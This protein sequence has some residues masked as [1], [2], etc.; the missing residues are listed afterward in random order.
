MKK[1]RRNRKVYERSTEPPG[2]KRR[3]IPDAPVDEVWARVQVLLA[4]EAEPT[5]PKPE[6]AKTANAETE[7]SKRSEHSS[8]RGRL[9]RKIW[10]LDIVAVAAWSFVFTKLFV[11][12]VDRYLL[13]AVAPELLW[14]LDYRVVLALLLL[15]MVLLLFKA[16]HVAGAI[17]YISAYPIVVLFW[18]VPL[19]VVKRWRVARRASSFAVALLNSALAWT[20][21][22]KWIMLAISIYTVSAL[23]IALLDSPVAIYTA[24]A[25]ML[26]TLGWSLAVSVIDMFRSSRLIDLQRR[27]ITWILDKDVLDRLLVPKHPD[28]VAIRDWTLADAKA[29][30]DS[31]GYAVLAHRLLELW[32]YAIDEYRRGPALV[33]QNVAA[34]VFMLIQ[35]VVVFSFIN[36]GIYVASS[37][38]YD[39][40]VQPGWWTWLYYSASALTFGEIDAIAP[41]GV[42][43]TIAK[44]MNGWIGGIGVLT[45]VVTF[46]ISIRRKRTEYA[47]DRSVKMLA[48][49][50]KSIEEM[51]RL[52]YKMGI[53]ELAGYL[54]QVAWGLNLLS[55]WLFEKIPME[56]RLDR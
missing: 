31:A 36:G 29:Y 38:Q 55:E 3:P 47:V 43:A 19:F 10:V 33:L 32:A 27:S 1:E 8:P 20:A 26:A 39:A 2:P 12:D 40:S 34:I 48:G 45:I 16:R 35:I 9:Q 24:A 15:S 5:G 18:K 49:K 30:R 50:A 6:V 54:T 28:R 11:A 53:D 41:T 44:L 23:V 46:V 14:L 25:A 4:E 42:I 22:A 21:R 56:R 52:E 17:A 51:S 37:E 7:K 13:G